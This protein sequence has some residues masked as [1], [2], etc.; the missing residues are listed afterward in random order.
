MRLKPI[1]YLM[2]SGVTL[3]F[4]VMILY[5]QMAHFFNFGFT[6]ADFLIKTNQTFLVTNLVVLLLL[7]YIMTCTYLGIFSFKITKFYEL[8]RRH[9]SPT[10]LVWC[11]SI[12]NRTL[13]PMCYNF[14][15]VT[16]NLQNENTVFQ[17]TLSSLSE[18]TLFGEY[19]NRY[20]FP[21]S[22]LIFFLLNLLNIF[23][24]VQKW[25]LEYVHLRLYDVDE[26]KEGQIAEGKA[27][28]Q[29]CM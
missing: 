12:L 25:V 21:I 1:V 2:L 27:V 17:E 20:F 14:L 4:S 29:A 18:P 9:S 22:L 10:T 11:G 15:A 7:G 13:Y 8:S 28:V 24:Y 23:S 16:K 3:L 19:T 6:F 5:D 26:F